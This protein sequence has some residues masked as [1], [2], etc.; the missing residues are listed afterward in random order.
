M[1][2]DAVA[3]ALNDACI[4]SALNADICGPA[5]NDT[6][7]GS[8][9]NVDDHRPTLNI[10]GRVPPLLATIAIWGLASFSESLAVLE[11]REA[12]VPARLAEASIALFATVAEG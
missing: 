8:A 10:E 1:S 9:V 2:M 3:S 7:T 5:L 6:G 4:G 12:E 11:A